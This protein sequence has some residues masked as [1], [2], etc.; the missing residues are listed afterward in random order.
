M[1]RDALRERFLAVLQELGGSA[2]NGKLR[3]ALGWQEETYWQVRDTLVA[4]GA[5]N[6][7]RGRGGSVAIAIVPRRSRP[8]DHDQM[9]SPPSCRRRSASTPSGAPTN[10]PLPSQQPTPHAPSPPPHPPP[11]GATR[12]QKHQRKPPNIAPNR[13]PRTPSRHRHATQF[14]KTQTTRHL[15]LRYIAFAGPRLGRAKPSARAGRSGH[16]RNTRTRRLRDQPGHNRRRSQA[17]RPGSAEQGKRLRPAPRPPRQ[18]VSELGWQSRAAFARRADTA[19]L[20]ARAAVHQSN[21]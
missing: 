3:E 5:V 2:G 16:S 21:H 8:A 18:A 10:Q 20:C 19:A 15:S 13:R 4:E 1:V 6:A 11:P 14:Q 9:P 7:G 12:N 17:E